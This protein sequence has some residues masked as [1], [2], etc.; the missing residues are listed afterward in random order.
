MGINKKEKEE[1][2]GK[3]RGN[4][5]SV[6]GGI[7]AVIFIICIGIILYIS[8]KRRI[9]PISSWGDVFV[10]LEQNEKK[11]EEHVLSENTHN[12]STTKSI[13][14]VVTNKKPVYT[15]IFYD[16]NKTT[17]LTQSS[18]HIYEYVDP[19]KL[20]ITKNE[21]REAENEYYSCMEMN[22]GENILYQTNNGISSIYSVAS[23]TRPPDELPKVYNPKDLTKITCN[24]ERKESY[25]D[26]P[27]PRPKEID[28]RLL[29]YRRRSSGRRRS[30]STNEEFDSNSRT[31]RS[32][33]GRRL[34]DISSLMHELP[35][36]KINRDTTSLEGCGTSNS[37]D[38]D[39]DQPSLYENTP[40]CLSVPHKK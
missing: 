9:G 1:F 18:E 36:N 34:S 21:G 17:K 32:N 26:P 13:A 33:S 22:Q 20:N 11:E 6:L 2:K 8:Y 25:K 3:K 23:D 37:K 7:I 4:V 28:P 10:C 16:K 40:R 24:M 15:A 12:A 14:P 31:Y 27:P 35:T 38:I 39:T 29:K 30:S 19:K 5:G